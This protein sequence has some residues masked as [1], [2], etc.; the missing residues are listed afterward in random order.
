M[1]GRATRRVFGIRTWLV[2]ETI[3]A[4]LRL[5]DPRIRTEIE[6]GMK[7]ARQPVTIPFNPIKRAGTGMTTCPAHGGWFPIGCMGICDASPPGT[8]SCPAM[9]DFRDP[10]EED[11]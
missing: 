4:L 9:H 3:D 8:R 10:D 1:R 6:R 11:A 2:L 5:A 7:L